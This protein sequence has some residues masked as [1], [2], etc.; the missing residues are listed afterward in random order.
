V[1]NDSNITIPVSESDIAQ[2]IRDT[3]VDNLL[4]KHLGDDFL[5]SLADVQDNT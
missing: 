4:R 1:W 3:R 2:T 5:I